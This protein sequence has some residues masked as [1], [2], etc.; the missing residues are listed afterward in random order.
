M[1]I[2]QT[3]PVPEKKKSVPNGIKFLFGGLSGMGATMVVQPLDLVKTRM[4]I[5]GAGSG[6]KE[7]RNSFHCIQTVV[8]REGPLGLYQGIGAALLRQAT[9]T[10]G[11][12]GMYTYLNDVYRS[13]FER[14]PNVMDS[15]AMGTIAGA[16]G[17][18]IGT[19]AEVALVRMTS[20]GRLPP[21]ERRNYKNVANALMRIT[22]EEGLTALWRGSL[23]TVGRAMVVNMTQLAS[24]SQF[25]TYFRTGPLQMDEGIK[26]H[27]CASMLSGLLT[28]ITSMPLDIAK[29]RIQNMKM[30]DGK[31]EYRGTVDVLLRV[32]RQEGVF[33]LWKGF[34]P[35]YC[36]LG[37][38]TVLTFI[39][40]EQLNQGFNKYVLG[41]EKS[42]SGL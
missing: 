12:L 33:A 8:S 1:S 35:Y 24:Y 19:P 9:Y 7:F 34:T 23:P 27:F 13:R 4:Q 36:R 21:A 28:T 32:A 11:R 5:S 10:T 14:E 31:P 42:G 3:V 2:A 30:V 41:V 18:F 38:H 17:A 15:M 39:L 16:C 20:D 26:L 37:P 22:K 25:K 6:K 29:T 40:L